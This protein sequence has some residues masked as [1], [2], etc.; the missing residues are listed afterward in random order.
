MNV[1]KLMSY[2]P[3]NKLSLSLFVV[4]SISSRTKKKKKTFSIIDLKKKSKRL[5]FEN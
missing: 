3:V 2:S 4:G 1:I 5:S